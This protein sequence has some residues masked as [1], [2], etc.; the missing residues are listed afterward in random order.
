MKDEGPG[1][2]KKNSRWTV[3]G[4]QNIDSGRLCVVYLLILTRER[5]P[6]QNNGKRKTGRP[7]SVKGRHPLSITKG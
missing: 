4:V 1:T 7:M 6:S 3:Y 2:W 5:D